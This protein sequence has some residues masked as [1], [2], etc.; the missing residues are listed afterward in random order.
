MTIISKFMNDGKYLLKV[1][2]AWMV[3]CLGW[4][5]NTPICHFLFIADDNCQLSTTQHMSSATTANRLRIP[6]FHP[7]DNSVNISPTKM[8]TDPKW[9]RPQTWCIDDHKWCQP[10]DS[11]CWLLFSCWMRSRPTGDIA[12]QRDVR[13]TFGKQNISTKRSVEFL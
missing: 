11:I 5:T 9:L 1:W 8:F 7:L 3:S 2:S 10:N 6:W 4:L 12:N 13:L